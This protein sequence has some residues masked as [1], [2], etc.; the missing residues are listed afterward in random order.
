VKFKRRSTSPLARKARRGFRGYPVATIAFYGPDNT[1]ASKV[2][3][4]IVRAEGA[5]PEMTRLFSDEGDIRKDMEIAEEILKLLTLYGVKSVAVTEGIFGCPHEE[6]KDY[7]DGEVCPQ[8][9]Y[10]GIFSM[11]RGN[12]NKVL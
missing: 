4:G 10:W 7:P 1:R 8:C 11:I 12:I 3:I 6:G 2:A 9:P 5:E